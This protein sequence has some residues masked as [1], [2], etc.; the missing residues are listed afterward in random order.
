M[1]RKEKF[2]DEKQVGK[3]N[4]KCKMKGHSAAHRGGLSYIQKVPAQVRT[5]SSPCRKMRSVDLWETVSPDWPTAD[6]SS[7]IRSR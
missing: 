4:L 2:E 1:Q 3:Y 7:S 6:H 5:P